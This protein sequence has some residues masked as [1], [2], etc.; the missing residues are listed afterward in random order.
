MDPATQEQLLDEAEIAAM[1]ATK[2]K[3][4]KDKK[5]AESET[6]VMDTV[7]PDED[8]YD[9]LLS[10]IYQIMGATHSAS[11]LSLKRLRRPKMAAIGT[12][13]VG[14][15]N[16]GETAETL[17]RTQEHLSSFIEAEFGTTISIDSKN[18]LI[19]KGRFSA[20]QIESVLKKYVEQYIKCKTCRSMETTLDKD[21][22]SRLPYLKCTVC[23]STWFVSNIQKGFHATMKGERKA[24]RAEK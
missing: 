7:D 23:L 24:A 3:K 19:I 8:T 20:E 11:E 16:F 12:K 4:K 6:G 13:R 21:L 14:W 15:V 18:C 2:K 22:A 9:S 5:A 17:N 1:F 10:R